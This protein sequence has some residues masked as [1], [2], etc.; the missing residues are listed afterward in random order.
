MKCHLVIVI[1]A[2]L[3][4]CG[5]KPAPVPEPESS[6]AVSPIGA[7]VG[8]PVEDTRP[9][10]PSGPIVTPSSTDELGQRIFEALQAKD[11]PRL[12]GYRPSATF[13]D[14]LCPEQS[15]QMRSAYADALAKST[16]GVDN[17]AVEC[18]AINWNG[19]TL[20]KVVPGK[21]GLPFYG[22]EPISDGSLEVQITLKSGQQVNVQV[23]TIY[24]ANGGVYLGSLPRCPVV[25]PCGDL[26]V[27]LEELIQAEPS[28]KLKAPLDGDTKVSVV[29]WCEGFYDDPA[30]R[31][32][33]DCFRQAK[34]YGALGNCPATVTEAFKMWPTK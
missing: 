23:P 16:A 14:R 27:H 18:D 24:Q 11:L 34:T 33:L 25:S 17:R 13:L 10:R 22:C 5:K 1:S 8:A 19:A 28:A 3:V 31:A 20:T 2:A 6:P 12:V 7:P 9:S 4:A 21:V 15:P 29:A 30:Q 32:R 26:V